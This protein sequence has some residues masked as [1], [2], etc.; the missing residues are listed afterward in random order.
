MRLF[1]EFKIKYETPGWSRDPELV[2]I[3]LNRIAT[4]EGKTIN[5][6]SNV[7]KKIHS[8]AC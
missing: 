8:I 1:E 4:E 2:L 3:E 5:Q 7:V 6:V